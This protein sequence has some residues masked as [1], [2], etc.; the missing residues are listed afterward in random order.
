MKLVL[1]RKAKCL[2]TIVTMLLCYMLLCYYVTMLRY[3]L[4][5]YYVTM[6]HLKRDTMKGPIKTQKLTVIQQGNL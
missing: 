5:C 2:E 3:M 4:L 1:D 6:L